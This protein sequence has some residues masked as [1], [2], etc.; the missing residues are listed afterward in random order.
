MRALGGIYGIVTAAALVIGCESSPTEPDL[1]AQKPLAPE[2]VLR[3]VVAPATATLRAGQVL[4][5]RAAAASDDRAVARTIAVSWRSSDES[6][7]TVSTTGLVRAVRPG[8]AEI[9]VRWGTSTATARITVLKGAPEVAC[10]SLI[11]KK[12]GC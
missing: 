6:I 2:P 8:L 1:P 10:L 4:G 9:Q 3:L 5:L 12:S 7:A 11:P